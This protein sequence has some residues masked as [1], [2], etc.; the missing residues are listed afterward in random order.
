M[1]GTFCL[2]CL[3]VYNVYRL[4]RLTVGGDRRREVFLLFLA[5]LLIFS[6]VQWENWFWGIQLIVFVPIVCVTSIL[7]RIPR[8]LWEQ[9]LRQAPFSRLSVRS[10]MRMEYR[11]GS[12]CFLCWCCR[13][14]KHSKQSHGCLAAG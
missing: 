5:S 8:F 1:W 12:L 2:A 13:H 7:S 4:G 3:V 11:V 6:L 9:S 14:G 10:P